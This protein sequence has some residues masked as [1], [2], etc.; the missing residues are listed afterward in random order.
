MRGDLSPALGL[1]VG[2]ALS[3]P[4][5]VAGGG[6]FE[7]TDQGREVTLCVHL[8]MGRVEQLM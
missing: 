7:E 5:G 2:G 1:L 3:P 6:C 4:L 8:E